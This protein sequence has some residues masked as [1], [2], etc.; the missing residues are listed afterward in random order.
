MHVMI[1]YQRAVSKALLDRI[2]DEKASSVTSVLMV[3]G[4]GWGPLV[5]ASLECIVKHLCMTKEFLSN[6]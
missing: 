5:R 1:Q 2:T 3:V 4:A 6:F